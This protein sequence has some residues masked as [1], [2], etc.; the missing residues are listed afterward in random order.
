[1]QAV[2]TPK[3]SGNY[4]SAFKTL[5]VMFLLAGGDM[6]KVAAK[7]RSAIKCFVKES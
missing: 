3:K 1:M 6:T 7:Y 2:K 5:L 4:Q